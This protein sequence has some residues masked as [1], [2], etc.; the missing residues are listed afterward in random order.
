MILCIYFELKYFLSFNLNF[1][2]FI[3]LYV[4][5]KLTKKCRSAKFLS[6]QN[7]K[8]RRFLDSKTRSAKSRFW[9]NFAEVFTEA[10]VNFEF[11]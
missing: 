4:S 11:S 2:Y 8:V 5:S 1:L 6:V 3:P 7:P 9:Q 10:E